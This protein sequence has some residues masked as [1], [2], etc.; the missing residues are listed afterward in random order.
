MSCYKL[1]LPSGNELGPVHCVYLD[2]YFF[3]CVFYVI[4]FWSDAK[5]AKIILY[6]LSWNIA[7]SALCTYIA[8][9]HPFKHG[10]MSKDKVCVV[11]YFSH[12]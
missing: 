8:V 11:L 5:L 1:H 10:S 6:S 9:L 2:S 3:V 12:C 7:L 4:Q